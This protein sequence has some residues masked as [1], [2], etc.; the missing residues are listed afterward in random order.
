MAQVENLPHKPTSGKAR[1]YRRR[2]RLREIRAAMRRAGWRDAFPHRPVVKEP[3]LHQ[4]GTALRWDDGVLMLHPIP[5]G[6]D[7]GGPMEAAIFCGAGGRRPREIPN[8]RG[9][10]RHPGKT[11]APSSREPWRHPEGCYR[12]P[13]YDD[14]QFSEEETKPLRKYGFSPYKYKT[15]KSVVVAEPW[16]RKTS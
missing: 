16:P 13:E 12:L 11:Q 9:V 2:K 4:P 6:Q 5:V 10:A 15:D 1:A 14:G 7:G 8:A 3:P